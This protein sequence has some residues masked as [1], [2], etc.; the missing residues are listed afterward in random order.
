VAYRLQVGPTKVG[1]QREACE[2]VEDLFGVHVR[3]CYCVI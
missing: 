1:E 2:S 3:G